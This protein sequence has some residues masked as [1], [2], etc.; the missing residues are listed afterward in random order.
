MI[1]KDYYATLNKMYKTQITINNIKIIHKI[2]LTFNI[3]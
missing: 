1:N 3:K 2:K